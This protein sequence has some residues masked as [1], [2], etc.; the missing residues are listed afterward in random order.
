ML[1]VQ[2]RSGL[3]EATHQ[4]AFA[5]FDA[6]L[7]LVAYSGDIDTPFFLRSSSKPFQAFVSQEFGAELSPI[8]LAIASSSHDGFPAHIA[9]V[10]AMLR[11]AGLSHDDLQCPPL[12]PLGGEAR[13]ILVSEGHKVPRPIWHDCSG[14]HAAWLRACVASD[15]PTDTY[16]A[17]DHPIQ[18]RVRQL[19]GEVG[20]HDVDPMGIDGCGAPV[21]RTTVRALARMYAVLATDHRFREVLGAMHRYPALVSGVGNGD[22]VIATALDAAAKRGAMGCIGVAWANQFGIAVKSFDGQDRAAAFAAASGLE[23]LS[24]LSETVSSSLRGATDLK[25]LGGGATVG[26]FESRLELTL[27]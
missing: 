14:K 1:A 3:V 13:D 5:A 7:N 9:V 2:V 4:G 6:S 17:P 27:L 22:A 15:L 23:N 26:R 11:R 20:D 24:N 8:E 16:L 18:A 25:V 12:W 21:H 10:D 19:I